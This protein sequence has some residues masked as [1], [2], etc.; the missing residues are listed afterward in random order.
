M[1]QTW[2][3][4]IKPEKEQRLREWLTEMQSRADAVRESFAA[5]GV[6]A[7]QALVFSDG[8]GPIL[9][10]VSEAADHAQAARA[11]AASGLDIDAEHRQ[12]MDECIDRTIT[13]APVFDVSV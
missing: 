7:E 3:H 12:V 6:R 8:A 9:V 13:D 1:L 2:I 11:Y 10:Y 4:R 5:A